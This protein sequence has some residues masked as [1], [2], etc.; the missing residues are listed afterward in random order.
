MVQRTRLAFF[1][2]GLIIICAFGAWQISDNLSTDEGEGSFSIIDSNEKVHHFD[3]EPSR[4]AITNTYAASVMK[5]LGIDMNVVVGVSGDFYDQDL[6][7]DLSSRDLIQQSAHSEIDFEALLD[8]RPEVYI[9]FATNG[10]VDT[11]SIREKLEPIGIKVLAFDF[12]K[13]DSLRTEMSV[14]AK[15]FG[16]QSEALD[17][18]AEFDAIEKLVEDRISGL[19]EEDRPNVVMEHHASLT[20]DPVVLTGT[21]Q[22]TDIIGMAGGI[23]V[24]ADLPGHT[25]HV[26]MEA[27]LD[28]NPDVLMFD[29]IV[30]DI[31]FNSFDDEGQCTT[32]MDFIKT[33]PGF[34]NM[35]AIEDDRMVIMSGEFAGPM[36]IHGLPSLAKILHPDLFEDVDSDS[37]IQDFFQNYHGVEMTGKFVCYSAG[38]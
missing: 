34:E 33:R 22:W 29:G 24:F 28:A 17:V 1:Q 25:T 18:F 10:M 12:Y 21:S 2:A 36:M 9:V 15:I 31:G 4:V 8:T 23:N 3:E 20:R 38:S 27:I 16:K 26:D 7:P 14:L 35:V 6:W 19:D 37:Y 32:H 11:N 30:F 13:Y 5:M